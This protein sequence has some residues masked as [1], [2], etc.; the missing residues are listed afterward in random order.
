MYG[1][2]IHFRSVN[3]QLWNDLELEG[4][5]SFIIHGPG[6]PVNLHV[7]FIK[8]MQCP[9]GMRCRRCRTHEGGYSL[10][11]I[12]ELKGSTGGLLIGHS[13]ASRGVGASCNDESVAGSKV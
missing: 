12:L 13:E 2:V 10:I 8:Q 9:E 11:A 5:L 4:E 7:N 3:W 1:A 6:E